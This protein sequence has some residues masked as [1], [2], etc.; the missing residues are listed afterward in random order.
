MTTNSA[1]VFELMDYKVKQS[2]LVVYCF[3]DFIFLIFNC[4][5]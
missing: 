3:H 4:L 1:V 5:I 2:E